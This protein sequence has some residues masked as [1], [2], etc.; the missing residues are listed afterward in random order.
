MLAQGSTAELSALVNL[1]FKGEA[2]RSVTKQLADLVAEL[3]G[4]FCDSPREAWHAL[5]RPTVLRPEELAA[6]LDRLAQVPLPGDKRVAAARQADLERARGEDW[7]SFTA[8]G[9]AGA[10]LNDGLYFKKPIDP[11][12]V[13]LYQPLLKHARGVIV[14]KLA[15]HTEATYQLLAAYAECYQRLKFGRRGLCFDDVPRLLAPASPRA[16]CLPRIGG[17]TPR[18][19]I[20]CSTNFRT[21]RW[22]SG[23]CSSRLLWPLATARP[24]TASFAWAT[25]SRPSIA[26]GAACHNCLPPCAMNC[27]ASASKRWPPAIAPARP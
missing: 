23:T 11:L 27:P 20:C 21:R 1:L 10:L 14:G 13:E 18:S 19:A 2:V 24:G 16:C 9:L 15:S 8:K 17:S 25:S 22:P 26:G 5:R 7:E 12:L 6:A 3:H 4:V